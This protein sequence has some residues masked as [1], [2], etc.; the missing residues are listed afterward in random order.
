MAVIPALERVR[1]SY[2]VWKIHYADHFINQWSLCSIQDSENHTSEHWKI[3]LNT[4]WRIVIIVHSPCITQEPRENI[5]FKPK[6]PHNQ[7]WKYKP[8][9]P[10]S[11]CLCSLVLFSNIKDPEEEYRNVSRML[12]LH[13]SSSAINILLPVKWYILPPDAS[14]LN[15]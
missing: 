1:F 4:N 5:T 7:M 2:F 15:T 10:I 12:Y 3:K 6:N 13:S 11:L 8:N 9:Y 14:V